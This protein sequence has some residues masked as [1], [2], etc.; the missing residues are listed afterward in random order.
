MVGYDVHGRRARTTTRTPRTRTVIVVTSGLAAPAG[1]EPRRPHD[2]ERRHRRRG[3]SSRGRR[4]RPD[5][6]IVV[7]TNPLDAMCHVALKASGFP[8]ERV[9]RHGRRPRHGPVP[10]PSSRGSSARRPGR[11]RG[12]SSAATATRWCPLPRYSTVGGVPIIGA[13][14]ERERIEAMVERTRNGGAE[15]VDAPQDR[16]RLVRARRASVVADGRVDPARPEAR[17]AVH[18]ATSR[19]STASTA[20]SW[21][22]RSCSATAGSRRS[23]R[24]S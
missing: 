23:S 2:E 18:R 17:A 21:A 10:R 12:S 5:A 16:Q 11:A 1:H 15:V 19:A 22:C 13:H 7:V 4:G 24:S 20:C 8:P 3:A 14:L 9:V 6:I